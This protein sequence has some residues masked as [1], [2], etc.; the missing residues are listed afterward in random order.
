AQSA[1]LV[2]DDSLSMSAERR[3]QPLYEGAR[4]RARRIVDAMGADADLAVVLASR[5]GG[6]PVPQLTADRTRIER[7]IVEVRPTYRAIVVIKTEP[8][9]HLGP[10]GVRVS[11]EVGNF[12]AEPLKE[13]AVTLRVDGKP[14]AKGLLD[15]PAKARAIK[16]FFHVFEHKASDAEIGVHDI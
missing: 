3:G 8:A 13:L 9:A 2:I 4:A 14:V 7:V 6:A 12:G 11:V 10:R 15:V 5:G 1:V 16:R